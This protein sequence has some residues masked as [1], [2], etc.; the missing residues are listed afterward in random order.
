[1]AKIKTSGYSHKKADQRKDRKRREADDRQ[2]VYDAL[3][4]KEK[5]ERMGKKHRA[6]WERQQAALA[7]KNP[8]KVVA[9]APAPVVVAEVAD[10]PKKKKQKAAKV[11]K[12]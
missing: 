7:K 1:M 11:L 2:A 6:R 9:P 10:A 5:L 8:V 12:S 4:L 3:P